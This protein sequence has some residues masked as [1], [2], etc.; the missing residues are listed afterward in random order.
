MPGP[1]T[2]SAGSEQDQSKERTKESEISEPNPEHKV[3]T[4]HEGEETQTVEIIQGQE[5]KEI[6]LTPE[7]QE[8]AETAGFIYGALKE[9]A[10]RVE[11]EGGFAIE[12][13]YMAYA[14]D[15]EEE[16]REFPVT[17]MFD[18]RREG[19]KDEKNGPYAV[20]YNPNSGLMRLRSGRDRTYFEPPCLQIA[21]GPDITSFRF[22]MDEDREIRSVAK[23]EGPSLRALR[24][25]YG[26]LE[27]ALGFRIRFPGE[28]IRVGEGEINTFVESRFSPYLRMYSDNAS[29]LSSKEI[30]TEMEDR[31]GSK[32]EE[33]LREELQ[34]LQ[35]Q[36]LKAEQSLPRQNYVLEYD[37]EKAPPGQSL[38]IRKE[39]LDVIDFNHRV[40]SKALGI[41]P[42]ADF[43]GHGGMPDFWEAAY[44]CRN[45]DVRKIY[46]ERTMHY[47][48]NIRS[49]LEEGT[50]E[51]EY[52]VA[53]TERFKPKK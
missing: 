37:P 38:R 34:Q 5:S 29:E 22:N 31:Y 40:V 27:R 3:V 1:E 28:P 24:K 17:F 49:A 10:E 19:D 53:R 16:A 2:G 26:D 32:S 12:N 45:E 43:R 35:Y 6:K 47:L 8:I 42:L 50:G 41:P 13:S 25:E 51:V 48:G 21:L 52:E 15:R 14:H 4:A 23:S 39:N 36:I 30:D 9:V 46:R 11:K 20:R 18:C 44:E 7:E 33:E